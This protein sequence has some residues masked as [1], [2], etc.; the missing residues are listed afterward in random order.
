M[1]SFPSVWLLHLQLQAFFQRFR[2]KRTTG[3][4]LRLVLFVIVGDHWC[5]KSGGHNPRIEFWKKIHLR[6]LFIHTLRNCK[7][8]CDLRSPR[9][10]LLVKCKRK[11]RT[12]NDEKI[13]HFTFGDFKD[14][15]IFK[16]YFKTQKLDL[17]PIGQC[18][19]I[20]RWLGR[21]MG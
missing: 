2:N 13:H 15:L 12:I 7:G 10:I 16:L 20:M 6:A 18:L 1:N 9:F 14:A 3:N 21:G 4:D 17:S 5:S 19:C 8:S 11:N